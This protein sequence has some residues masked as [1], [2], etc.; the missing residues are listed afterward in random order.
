[1]PGFLPGSVCSRHDLELAARRRRGSGATVPSQPCAFESSSLATAGTLQQRRFLN[2][3]T[4]Y[5]IFGNPS[6]RNN[7]YTEPAA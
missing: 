5:I 7:D 1:M 2:A 3:A 6:V 4:V